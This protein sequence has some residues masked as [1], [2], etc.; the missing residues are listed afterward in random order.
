VPSVPAP[1]GDAHFYH[2]ADRRRALRLLDAVTLDKGFA[3]KRH[4]V[5][6]GDAANRVHVRVVQPGDD[7]APS[8]IDHLSLVP[9]IGHDLS[10]GPDG[11]KGPTADRSCGGQGPAGTQRGQ[12]AIQQD[13]VRPGR[14]LGCQP[15]GSKGGGQSSGCPHDPSPQEGS[16]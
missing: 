8:D 10:V 6:D 4:A 11:D 3:L 9:L 5:L 7:G 15:S 14:R 12:A 13:D 16:S 2:A 1:H